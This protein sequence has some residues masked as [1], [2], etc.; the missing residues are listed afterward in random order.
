[1]GQKQLLKL[2]FSLIL[3]LHQAMGLLKEKQSMPR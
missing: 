2:P 3:V 1:V